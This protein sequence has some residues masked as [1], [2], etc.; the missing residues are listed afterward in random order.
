MYTSI[1]GMINDD[2][3]VGIIDVNHPQAVNCSNA[4]V[5][6]DQVWPRVSIACFHEH[7]PCKDIYQNIN[8]SVTKDGYVRK[9]KQKYITLLE[10][11][12]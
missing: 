6:C 4:I 1:R 7:P 11:V 2:R 8:E 3:V 5:T 10:P 12:C 9:Y